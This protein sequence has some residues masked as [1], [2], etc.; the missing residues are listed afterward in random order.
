M[1]EWMKGKSLIVIAAVMLSCSQTGPQRPSQRMGE[2][3]KADSAQIALMEMNQRL[4]AAADETLMHTVQAQEEDYALY[5]R[6]TWVHI[7]D[8]GDA[9]QGSPQ[10]ECTVHM[11]VYGLNGTL[12]SDELIS[13]RIG[14]YELPQAID[15]NIS[16]WN[17][18]A[19]IRMYA[20]WYAAY[21]MQGTTR[22]PGYENVIIELEI[23]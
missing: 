2:S 10:E 13:A 7:A 15:A 12:Y 23:K 9:A 17:H 16:N 6:G 8:N 22:I 20:P 1:D 11:R 4:A 14:K 21:G 5:E 3:P 18:G 19:K